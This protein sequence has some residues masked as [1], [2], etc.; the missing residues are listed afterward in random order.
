ME[1]VFNGQINISRDLRQNKQT[2]FG[3]YDLT[4]II[5]LGLGGSVAIIVAY[6]LGFLLKVVDEYVAIMI[7]LIPMS[8]IINL[9][10]RRVAGMRHYNFLLLKQIEKKSR[11]R[12][13]RKRE[14]RE[15]GVKEEKKIKEINKYILGIE[16]DKKYVNKYINL[17]ISYENIERIAV[18]YKKSKII[19]M[20]EIKYEVGEDIL[21]DLVEKFSLNKNI[22]L[23]SAK[24]I[25]N[26]EEES[27]K[28]FLVKAKQKKK[29]KDKDKNEEIKNIEE[30]KIVM[31]NLYEVDNYRK[32]I[33]IIRKQV[34]V[35]SY[36]KKI[37][38]TKYVNTFI[39]IEEDK[40]GNKKY[41][42]FKEQCEKYG[43][44]IDNLITEKQGAK[45]AISYYMTNKFNAYRIYK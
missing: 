6:T 18:H 38:K 31:M 27:S 5:F 28:R 17:F 19:F 41:E 10:F 3:K 45:R 15:E 11:Y 16:V 13:N 32:F 40:K 29:K 21:N 26:L 37:K 42:K 8:L 24:D 20:I 33:S 34:E 1:K 12:Q 23:L 39:V 7:S 2:V 35:V 9:G 14:I 43:V 36:F 22:E 30:P 4:D 25:N 44:V